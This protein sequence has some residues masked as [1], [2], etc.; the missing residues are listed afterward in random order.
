MMRH[1]SEAATM[2]LPILVAI[3]SV[4][5]S[6]LGTVMGGVIV[7]YGNITLAKKKEKLEFRTACRLIA[8]EL[9]IAELT[10]GL[11]L[12]NHCWWRSDEKLATDAWEQYRHILAPQISYDAWSDVWLAVR[13]VNDA[14]ALA[15]APRPQGSKADV[16]LP[17]TENALNIL[18]KGFE[19]ARI[20]LMPHGL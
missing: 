2:E 8:T 17:E 11:A 7:I 1:E 9:Q 20:A 16:L 5:G 6:L 18:V 10:L 15:A 4:S 14:R 12:K 19:R 3:I 13:G